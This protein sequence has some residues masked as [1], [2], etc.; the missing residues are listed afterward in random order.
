MSQFFPNLPFAIVFAV[1]LMGELSYLVW[2]DLKQGRLPNRVTLT[3]LGSGFVLSV[4]RGGWVSAE[5]HKVWL[6]DA[7]SPW[8]GGVDGALFALTGFLAGFGFFFLLWIFGVGGGGDVKLVGAV[9]AWLGPV[10]VFLAIFVSIPFLM[11]LALL[12]ITYRL[13]G[14]RLPEKPTSPLPGRPNIRRPMT[15]F[16]L[17]FC[18]G[19]VVILLLWVLG[20]VQ[21]LPGIQ[22][23]PG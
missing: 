15:T 1:I 22:P 3:L 18:L 17:S 23:G 21:Q 5:G 4:V 14:G 19:T 20:F 7:G 6:F 16:A 12:T 13:L 2:C 8:L 10:S 11:L 9:G